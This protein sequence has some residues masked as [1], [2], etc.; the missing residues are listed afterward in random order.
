MKTRPYI[1]EILIPEVGG[2]CHC[3]EPS[4]ERCVMCSV[5]A[6]C[7]WIDQDQS[8]VVEDYEVSVNSRRDAGCVHA[9]LLVHATVPLDDICAPGEHLTC[10]AAR[11]EVFE[12][13]RTAIYVT[14]RRAV[15]VRGSI[16][17]EA[18]R[19]RDGEEISDLSVFMRPL[20]V[21]EIADRMLG[22]LRSDS[23]TPE[24][25]ELLRSEVAERFDTDPEDLL[26]FGLFEALDVAEG[27]V[28]KLRALSSEPD[29]PLLGA[30][31]RSIQ[32]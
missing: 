20:V 23:L 3:N 10:R 29:Q 1:V 11:G 18:L 13:R 27:I 14:A 17:Q 24:A 8:T 6:G 25:A 32:R 15:Y 28:A 4:C 5:Y 2:D 31:Q 16:A 22:M 19:G 30:D 26:D 12:T 21:A 7:A 9:R